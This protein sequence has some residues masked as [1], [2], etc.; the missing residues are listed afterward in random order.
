MAKENWKTP[1]ARMIKRT[2]ETTVSAYHSKVVFTISEADVLEM[3]K[4]AGSIT[5]RAVDFDMW[6]IA[7]VHFESGR[8]ETLCVLASGVWVSWINSNHKSAQHQ[9]DRPPAES[10]FISLPV[11]I[12]GLKT[13]HWGLVIIKDLGHA[14][15]DATLPAGKPETT[16][17]FF[18]PL[19]TRNKAGN[20]HKVV[21]ELAIHL[22]GL[23]FM[24]NKP[25]VLKANWYVCEVS[26]CVSLRSHTRLPPA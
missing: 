6:K 11:M 17:Y 26:G 13:G 25:V 24:V 22:L 15:E 19:P 12:G 7:G 18:D 14:I 5:A 20:I 16:F 23:G 2:R 3:T 10:Q 8:P 4:V 9:C 1:S 21:R